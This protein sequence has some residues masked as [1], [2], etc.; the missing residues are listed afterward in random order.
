M[1]RTSTAKQKEDNAKQIYKDDPK[2]GLR[3]A[4]WMPRATCPTQVMLVAEINRRAQ[5]LNT[6][7]EHVTAI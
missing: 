6:T 4:T 5:I 2:M 1:A 7:C 3:R